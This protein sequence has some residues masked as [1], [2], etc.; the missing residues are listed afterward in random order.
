V[1]TL[2]LSEKPIKGPKVCRNHVP[3]IQVLRH[4]RGFDDL[5]EVHEFFVQKAEIQERPRTEA[6]VNEGRGC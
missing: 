4:S 2:G 6:I 3:W 5:V 1:K